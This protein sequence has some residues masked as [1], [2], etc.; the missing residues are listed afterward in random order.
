[1]KT[2]KTFLKEIL[3]RNSTEEMRDPPK[4]TANE[5]QTEKENINQPQNNE[6]NETK[7]H[8]NPG[9]NSVANP[10]GAE[11]VA[12]PQAEPGDS[13]NAGESAIE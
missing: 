3:Y 2:I 6:E 11:S 12:I 8:E 1:M 7:N 4:E 10:G 5:N 13:G 9:D